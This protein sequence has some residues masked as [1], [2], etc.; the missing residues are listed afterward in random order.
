MVSN[1]KTENKSVLNRYVKNSLQYLLITGLVF[2]AFQPSKSL[3]MLTSYLCMAK[4]G[5]TALFS[6]GFSFVSNLVMS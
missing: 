1:L 2:G 5:A 6:N 3:G 4:A